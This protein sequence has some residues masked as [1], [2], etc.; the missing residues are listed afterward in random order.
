MILFNFGSEN[1]VINMGDR[2]AQLIF[3]KIKTPKI[4]ET[5]ELEGTDRGV[6]G[7]GSTGTKAVQIQDDSKSNTVKDRMSKE[8]DADMK[9]KTKN[10]AVKNETPLSQSRRLI[11]ARQMSKLAKG[12]NH[13]FL[14]IIQETNEAP[15]M[16][17]S[18]KRSSGRAARF[19]VAHGMSEGNKRSIN[20]REGPEKRHYFCC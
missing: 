20:K 5:N 9:P 18:N 8:R 7:Y 13:V 11:T 10:D 6:G 17:K 15:Q 2:I 19:A 12:D 1:F 16:K 4:K 3:E 14:A